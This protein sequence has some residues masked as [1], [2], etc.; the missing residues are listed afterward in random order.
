MAGSFQ[1]LPYF[2]FGN[3]GELGVLGSLGEFGNLGVLGELG[4]FIG[5]LENQGGS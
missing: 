5:A 1:G 4:F 3:L 2:Y